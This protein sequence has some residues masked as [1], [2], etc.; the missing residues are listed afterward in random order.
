MDRVFRR[1]PPVSPLASCLCF[2]V[3]YL[4]VVILL[5]WFNY[6]F[7]CLMFVNKFFPGE[8]S[9]LCSPCI[10]RSRLISA[11]SLKPALARLEEQSRQFCPRSERGIWT[12]IAG[13]SLVWEL[14]AWGKSVQVNITHVGPGSWKPHIGI[15]SFGSSLYFSFFPVPGK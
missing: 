15:Y 8:H 9:Y 11:W 1:W 4:T 6:S 14:S 10:P 13:W 7:H 5:L 3:H 12:K 2:L